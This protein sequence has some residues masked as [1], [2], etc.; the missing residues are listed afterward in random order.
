MRRLEGMS[1][2]DSWTLKRIWTRL[3]KGVSS[4]LTY[5]SFDSVNVTSLE[6]LLCP[7]IAAASSTVRTKKAWK[8]DKAEDVGFGIS[9]TVCWRRSCRPKLMKRTSC[10]QEDAG[11][12]DFLQGHCH[13]ILLVQCPGPFRVIGLASHLASHPF[14]STRMIEILEHLNWKSIS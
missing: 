11:A 8:L 7:I 12:S 9:Y 6:C 3:S 5:C 4:G 14:S 1:L 13:G 2:I 10:S